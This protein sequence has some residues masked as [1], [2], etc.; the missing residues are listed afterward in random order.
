MTVR[1]IDVSHHQGA[2]DWRKV[3]AGGISAAYC[4]VTQ[5][6]TFRDDRWPENRDNARAAGLKLAGYHFLTSTTPVAD[7]ARNLF[8]HLSNRD[9]PVIVDCEEQ[10]NEIGQVVSAPT[11]GMVRRFIAECVNLRM[12]V[13]ML[14]LPRWY[15]RQLGSP[16]LGGFPPLIQSAYGDDPRGSWVELYPGDDSPRWD[17]DGE[18]VA[19]LQFGQRGEVDGITGLVDVDAYRGDLAD[20]DQWFL[21]EERPK[22]AQVNKVTQ[23]T[24]TTDSNGEITLNGEIPSGWSEYVGAV[25]TMNT[26]DGWVGQVRKPG[27][28]NSLVVRVFRRKSDGT[29]EQ[30]ANTQ[31]TFT[32]DLKGVS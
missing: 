1:I 29:V 30:P 5:G 19:I 27:T 2:I 22:V 21:S 9:I 6:A 25:A 12:R 26:A 31:V 14:Y 18:E 7:Q 3:A 13:S 11:L 23:Q 15:W 28:N 10:R 16:D 32:L 24:A 4:K 17:Y 8:I 20:L